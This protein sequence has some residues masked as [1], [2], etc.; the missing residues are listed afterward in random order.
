MAFSDPLTIT[1]G[2]DS[3]ELPRVSS[4]DNNA[5]YTSSDGA[6]S[7]SA[8]S[9]YARRTRR[10]IRLDAN[11]FSPDPF[12]PTNN[13]KVSASVYTVVDLSAVGWNNDELGQMWVGLNNLLADDTYLIMT[14]LL[15][16][17]S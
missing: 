5:R 7:L 17:Q 3:I 13:T 12:I 11:K 10:V 14:Q 8:S 16:G 4:G 15:S 9:N 6:Y 2:P 1:I